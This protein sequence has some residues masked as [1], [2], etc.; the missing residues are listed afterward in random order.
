MPK[1]SI[2]QIRKDFP[3]LSLKPNGKNLVYLDSAATSQKPAVVINKIKSY[4]EETN[5]NVH[6]GVHYL[7]EKAT[8]EYEGAR[9]KAAEFVKAQSPKEIIFAKNAT[10]GIN[11]VA[12]SWGH[13]NIGKGDRILL[14][15]MEHHSNIVP[16]QILAKEKGAIV[17]YVKINDRFELDLKDFEQKIGKRPKIFAFTAVSNVLGTINPVAELVKKAKA[18]NCATL[19]DAAQAVPHMAVDVQEWGCDFIVFS[20][21]KMCAPTGIGVLYGRRSVL[22]NMEPWMGGGDMIKE[23]HLDGFSHNELPWKFEAGTPNIE[24]AIGLAAAIDY[25][26]KVGMQ[27]IR[28]HEKEITQYAIGKL[29]QVKGLQFYCPKNPDKQGGVISFNVGDIHAHDLSSIL[30]EEGIAIRSGHHCA[31]PLMEKLGIASAARASF[32]F[33]TTA[34]EIDALAA[35]LEKAREVFKL[36]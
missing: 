3:I 33:Y 8:Q 21:H 29:S 18:F 27:S 25:L 5:A 9:K 36:K 22:E 34:A 12:Q 4:Y 6:R 24:G 35:A 13:T 2:E 1:L 23:V 17:E 31:Q 32:Y 26:Q 14:T 30:D 10:E 19:V 20:G 15:E 7:S 16:W 11:L 28:E